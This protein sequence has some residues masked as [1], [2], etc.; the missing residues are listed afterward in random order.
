MDEIN[1]RLF[2]AAARGSLSHALLAIE[3]GANI[4]ARDYNNH[5]ALFIARTRNHLELAEELVK[6]GA[7]C[8]TEAPPKIE[9]RKDRINDAMNTVDKQVSRCRSEPCKVLT[10]LLSERSKNQNYAE[11]AL[12]SNFP[13][14]VAAAMM[15][16]EQVSIEAKPSVS[17]AFL[18]VDGY[19]ALRGS[20]DPAALCALLERVF[21]ALDA[22]AAQHGV[23]RIDAIDGFYIA[24]AKDR[25]SVV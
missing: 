18:E 23:E 25:K 4:N 9:C 5:S 19:S 7:D 15:R 20:A 10:K 16:C 17:I 12:A 2:R 14:S 24:A 1:M 8:R 21:S 11:A 6:L 3:A 22:L 13:A